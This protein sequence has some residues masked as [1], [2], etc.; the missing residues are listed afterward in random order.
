MLF[1][2][3]PLYSAEDLHNIPALRG[4]EFPTRPDAIV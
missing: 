1:W 3:F 4:L 2:F